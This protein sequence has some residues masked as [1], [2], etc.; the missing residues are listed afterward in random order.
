MGLS[1]SNSISQYN[2]LGLGLG[3]VW[4]GN[5]DSRKCDERNQW[6]MPFFGVCQAQ[7]PLVDFHSK[8]FNY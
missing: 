2:S 5:A 1:S 8:N 3:L 7:N 4:N 6:E